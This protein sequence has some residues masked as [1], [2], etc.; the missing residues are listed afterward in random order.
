MRVE[1][2][3]PTCGRN[4][5][6]GASTLLPL[7]FERRVAADRRESNS[8]VG[9]QRV[10]GGVQLMRLPLNSLCAGAWVDVGA[11][12]PVPAGASFEPV[13]LGGKPALLYVDSGNILKVVTP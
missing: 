13:S 1:P 8:F 3:T 12:V 6:V 4:C 7:A 11:A 5:P 9:A 10:A 2:Y